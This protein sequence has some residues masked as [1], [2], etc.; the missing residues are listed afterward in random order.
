M[1]YFFLFDIDV[2]YHPLLFAPPPP[3]SKKSI[4][5]NIS[6]RSLS[7]T[8]I[9]NLKHYDTF[10][11]LLAIFGIVSGQLPF[12]TF[13]VP[14]MKIIKSIRENPPAQISYRSYKF[15]SKNLEYKNPF[16]K[17]TCAHIMSELS[18]ARSSRVWREKR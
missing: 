16:E 3:P 18:M 15:L 1:I 13:S 14:K 6:L 11:D 17:F 4:I 12:S 8:S 7:S 5:R 9:T 10:S 2:W